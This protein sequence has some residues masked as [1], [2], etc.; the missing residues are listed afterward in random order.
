MAR[1]V[2]QLLVASAWLLFVTLTSAQP[3]IPP[4]NVPSTEEPPLAKRDDST[5]T[6]TVAILVTAPGSIKIGEPIVYRLSVE[7][8]SQAAAHHVLVSNA[9][10]KNATFVKANPEPSEKT[11]TSLRWK[12]GT[13]EPKAKQVIELTLLPSGDGDIVNVA[14]VQFEHGEQVVTRLRGPQLTVKKLGAAHAHENEA[15]PCRLIVENTGVV[16]LNNIVLKETVE[17]GLEHEGNELGSKAERTWDIGALK[18]GEKREVGYTLIAKRAG[19]LSSTAV[20]TDGKVRHETK[21]TVDV[22]KAQV[23]VQFTGPD[24]AYAGQPAT[25]QAV[26]KNIGN[27]PLDNV[28]VAYYTPAGLRVV[29]A[30]RDAESFKDRVQWNIARFEAGG[31]RTFRFDVAADKAGLVEHKVAVLAKGTQS[32][33]RVVT[34]FLGAIGL[35]LSIQE[36]DDPG[37]KGAAVAYTLRVANTGNTTAEN[38]VLKID[39]PILLMSFQRAS[40][41]HKMQKDKDRIVLDPITIRG[42]DSVTITVSMLA[43]QAGVARFHVEMSGADLDSSRPV[44][45]EESTTITD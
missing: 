44:I 21:W 22:G 38:V 31:T 8:R 11:E 5:P 7:N 35:R 43:Q 36:S 29:R 39:Y 13:L 25:Y 15:I 41:P 4:Q 16:E 24:K 23:D 26:V 30:S 33:A 10:P 1:F 32:S 14:R 42:R 18:P 20:A 37:R 17:E 9:I 28:A 2:Q 12:L 45:V 6:P 19:K 34:D 27:I 40:V 3:T